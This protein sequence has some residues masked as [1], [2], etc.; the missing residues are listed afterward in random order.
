MSITEPTHRVSGSLLGLT[1]DRQAE[2]AA[3]NPPAHRHYS[4]CPNICMLCATKGSQPSSVER[5][6]T[7][8]EGMENIHWR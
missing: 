3:Q 6:Q 5:I 8:V 4:I 1:Q 2:L 7:V